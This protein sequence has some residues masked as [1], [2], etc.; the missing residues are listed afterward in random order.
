MDEVKI[1]KELSLEVSIIG[2]Q[3]VVCKRA[4]EIIR[5]A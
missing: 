2:R 4:I 1:C 3:R 5:N